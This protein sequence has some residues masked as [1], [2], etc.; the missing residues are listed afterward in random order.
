MM[1]KLAKLAKPEVSISVGDDGTI[2]IR[3]GA[4]NRVYDQRF[5]LDTPFE[6]VKDFP[7]KKFSVSKR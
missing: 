7:K 2:H 6:L 3:T 1:R 5:T 4:G